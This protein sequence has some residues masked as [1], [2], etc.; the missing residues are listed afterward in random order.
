MERSIFRHLLRHPQ[1]YSR[2]NNGFLDVCI[3]FDIYPYA[4]NITKIRNAMAPI[5]K[6]SKKR[7]PV[8][9]HH[10]KPMPGDIRIR[11]SDSEFDEASDT[12]FHEENAQGK[13]LVGQDGE[14]AQDNNSDSEVD[15]SLDTEL[16]EENAQGNDLVGQDGDAQ[17]DDGVEEDSGGHST[18]RINIKL[19]H[20]ELHFLGLA[21]KYFVS[22][23]YLRKEDE[24]PPSNKIHML[25][26]IT[27]KIS[28]PRN[29]F[30]PQKRRMSTPALLQSMCVDYEDS[31]FM[32]ENSEASSEPILIPRLQGVSTDC[33]HR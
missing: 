15:E 16:N 23:S 11:D 18:P 25:R 28:K 19:L 33:Q 1:S 20:R 32:V 24:S 21:S 13:D 12:K 3:I 5:N 22:Y 9:E 4:S 31:Q 17:S 27:N 6:W 26:E 10:Y 30:P 2:N 8:P 7:L 14:N 29:I